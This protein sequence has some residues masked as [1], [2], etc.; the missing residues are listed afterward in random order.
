MYFIMNTWLHSDEGRK[1]NN[2]TLLFSLGTTTKSE[3]A[4]LLFE[5]EFIL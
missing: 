1:I 2:A 5:A 4:L 3:T